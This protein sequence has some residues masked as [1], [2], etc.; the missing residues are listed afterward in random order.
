VITYEYPFSERVRTLL[1]LES[2]FGRAVYFSRLDGAAENHVALG[3]IFEILDVVGRSDLKVDLFQELERQKQVLLGF[4]NNPGVSETALSGALHEIEQASAALLGVTGK[5]GQHLRDNDWL[6]SIKSRAA[7]PG[8]L[9]E[10]D[11]PS[12]HYW[13]N[14]PAQNRHAD[15][16]QWISTILPVRDALSIILRLLRTSGQAEHICA[17]RGQYQRMP[18]STTAQMACITLSS[19]ETAIPEVSANR[20]ALNIRFVLPFEANSRPHHI[21]ERNVAFDLAICTL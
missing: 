19:E 1:R 11:L 15:L 12:Y 21:C 4:C 20:Y 5:F 7:I 18:G 10:F 9:C 3:G 17:V 16:E 6:M 8:G 2:L 13:L 14:Q